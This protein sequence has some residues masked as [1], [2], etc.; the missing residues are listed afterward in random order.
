M[1]LTQTNWLVLLMTTWNHAKLIAEISP[2]AQTSP[3]K[4]LVSTAVLFSLLLPQSGL[5]QEVKKVEITRLQTLYEQLLVDPSDNYTQQLIADERTDIRN[6]IEDELNAIIGPVLD[7]EYLNNEEE[8]TNAVD[9]QRK[10]I[11][12]LQERL[13]DRKADLELL[14]T[15]EQRFYLSANAASGASAAKFRLTRTYP[16][17]LAKKAVLEERLLVLQQLLVLQEARLEQLVYDQRLRQF[18]FLITVAQ[19]LLAIIVVVI[20]ERIIRR[21]IIS[22]IRNTEHRYTISKI[23]SSITYILLAVWIILL[24]VSKNPQILASIAIVGA[25]LAIALQDVVKD[26][27]A[28]VI[29]LQHRLFNRGDRITVG[30][31]TGEVIDTSPLRTVLLEIGTE[32]THPN[33]VL[34]RTGKTLSIPN[35]QFLTQSLINHSKSSDYVRAEMRLV[36]TFESNWKKAKELLKDILEQ[37]VQDFLERDRKQSNYRLQLF[38]YPNSTMGNQVFTDIADDGVRFTLR[39][40]TPIGERR[41]IVDM[42]TGLILDAFDKEDDIELAYKTTRIRSE[43]RQLGPLPPTPGASVVG[44]G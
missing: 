18:A 13:R 3:M 10:A 39:F 25:G 21:R 20:A 27:I 41:P 9:R 44:R 28:W 14:N 40:T 7:E 4:F 19:Y 43:V 32:I 24:S 36:I 42:L 17:L 5:A 26:L 30:T 37:N 38:Y 11:G 15:E 31:I 22:R 6:I 29:I 2:L 23:V 34:E 16:E 8:L 33:S 12:V 1:C 35:G